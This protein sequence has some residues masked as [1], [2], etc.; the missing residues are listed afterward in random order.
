[1]IVWNG[2]RPGASRFGCAASS[3]NP[4]P[5]F[6]RTM[7]VPGATTPEPNVPKTLWISEIA[8]PSASTAQ[9]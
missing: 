6:W 1:M 9:R 4:A 2:R 5:R 7:P 3:T 8:V